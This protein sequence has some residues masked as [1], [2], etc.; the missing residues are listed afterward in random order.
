MSDT[1]RGYTVTAYLTYRG[2][3]AS[4]DFGA[5]PGL[6]LECDRCGAQLA[7]ETGVPLAA[8]VRAATEH[9]GRCLG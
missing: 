7:D 4:A 2:A 3:T 1:L 9:S 8:L 6:A 5:T